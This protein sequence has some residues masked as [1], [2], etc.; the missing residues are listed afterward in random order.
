MVT[1]IENDKG[2]HTVLKFIDNCPISERVFCEQ[3]PVYNK[4]CRAWSGLCDISLGKHLSEQDT[5][6]YLNSFRAIQLKAGI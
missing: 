3:C 5:N 2:F 6:R 4:C 1:S